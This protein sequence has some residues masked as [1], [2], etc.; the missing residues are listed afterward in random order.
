MYS[1]C[2]V[3]FALTP[4]SACIEYRLFYGPYEQGHIR[5]VILSKQQRADDGTPQKKVQGYRVREQPPH[6]HAPFLSGHRS[7]GACPL[8]A[9]WRCRSAP[10]RSPP[11]V[12]GRARWQY[13]RGGRSSS[14]GTVARAPRGRQ[15]NPACPRKVR[16]V[17]TCAV[18]GLSQESQPAAWRDPDGPPVRES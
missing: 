2:C 5:R 10:R 13:R 16:H 15:R 8:R 17:G 18:R 11:L 4:Q 6:A 14:S 12:G 1:R 3:L 7:D 9:G